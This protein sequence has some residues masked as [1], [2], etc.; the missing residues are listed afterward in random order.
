MGKDSNVQIFAAD[1][2]DIKDIDENVAESLL[3]KYQ[4]KADSC[5]LDQ[6]EEKSF[7]LA[8]S[9]I[10]KRIISATKLKF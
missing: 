2:A 5:T 9:D 7:Y 3:S 1:V 6:F 4:Q 10:A 8:A